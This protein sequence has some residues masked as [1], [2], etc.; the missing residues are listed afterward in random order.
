MEK[1]GNRVDCQSL[2]CSQNAVPLPCQRL[3]YRV[4]FIKLFPQPLGRV[5]SYEAPETTEAVA[6]G[7]L[8]P[9]HQVSPDTFEPPFIGDWG[10]ASQIIPVKEQ[11]FSPQIILD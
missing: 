7:P 8:P 9:L 10:R 3:F 6:V 4:K 5:C 2:K 1:N 11:S